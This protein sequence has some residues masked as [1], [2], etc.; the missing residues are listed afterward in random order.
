MSALMPM[1]KS[2]TDLTIIQTWYNVAKILACTPI[3]REGSSKKKLLRFS[4]FSQIYPWFLMVFYLGATIFSFYERYFLYK[5][6]NMSQTILDS[7]QGLTEC[8][9]IEHVVI[10]SVL[11]RNHWKKMMKSMIQLDQK[12]NWTLNHKVNDSRIICIRLRILLYHLAYFGIHIYDSITNW[13]ITYYSLAF[14]IFRFVSYYIMF[15]TL[16]ITFIC[17]WIRNRYLYLNYFLKSTQSTTNLKFAVFQKESACEKIKEF[18]EMYKNLYL[19]VQEINAVFGSYFFLITICAVLETLNAVNYGMKGLKGGADI[20][21]IYVNVLYL[22][23]YM[24]S[25]HRDI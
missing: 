3:N 2:R 11:K 10:W 20:D 23:S 19:I 7:M 12:I 18:S 22:V 24:V 25:I 4:H 21:A 14:V 8:S 5:Y 13:R 9:F 6:F 16:F 15:S 1:N 17:G